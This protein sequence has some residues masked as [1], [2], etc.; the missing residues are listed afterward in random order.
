MAT[1]RKKTTGT[2]T[3]SPVVEEK[4]NTVEKE[5]KELKDKL[6]EQEAQMAELQKKMDALLAGISLNSQ[7]NASTQ[8]E[9]KKIKFINL[10]SG[11]FTLRGSRFYHLEKQFDYQLFSENEAHLIVNNMPQSV[12]NGYIYI[13][14]ADFVEECE[15]DN[16]YET[17]LSDKEL[18]ELLNKTPKDVCSIYR[19]ASEEQKKIILDM[20]VN[21]RLNGQEIDAN[22]LLELGKLSGKDLLE[23][24]P[25]DGE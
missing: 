17:M 19:N 13:A 1:T 8:K 2:D 7:T 4:T 3:N 9:K 21:K 20:I 12:T 15:L 24:E 5:N 6:K 10:T 14:D 22:I 11:G 16:V 23:I 25:L 18:K